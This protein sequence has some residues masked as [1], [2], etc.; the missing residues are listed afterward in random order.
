M[1][2]K[3]VDARA[4]CASGGGLCFHPTLAMVVAQ[5]VQAARL[6]AVLGCWRGLWRRERRRA[7]RVEAWPQKGKDCRRTRP[8]W[9]RVRWQSGR[10]IGWRAVAMMMATATRGAGVR[11]AC[12]CRVPSAGQLCGSWQLGAGLRRGRGWKRWRRESVRRMT[13]CRRQTHIGRLA[14]IGKTA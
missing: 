1:R 11:L 5:V 10:D 3:G 8:R 12:R 9:C 4:G 2:A 14:P 7:R 6:V 13:R